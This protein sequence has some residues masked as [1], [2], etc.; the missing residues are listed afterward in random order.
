MQK[1]PKN[2]YVDNKK[3]YESIVAYKKK[4][5][6]AEEAGLPKPQIPEYAGQCIKDIAENVGKRVYKFAGYSYNDEMISDSI[7]NCI[8]Y[9][10][11]FDETRF[12]NPH[13]YFTRICYNANANRIKIEKKEKYAT[14]KLFENEMILSANPDVVFHESHGLINED[15]YGNISEY[16]EDFEIKEKRRKAERKEKLKAKKMRD[17]LE[18]FMKK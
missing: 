9:F 7:L 4:C 2:H 12:D 11:N 5:R 8:T 1:K 18:R 15:I 14:Y 13:A 17:S 10:D 3:F 6:D 16:I